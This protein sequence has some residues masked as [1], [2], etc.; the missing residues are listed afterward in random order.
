MYIHTDQ[1]RRVFLRRAAQLSVAGVAAPLVGSLGIASEAAAATADDYKALVCVF[2][3]GGNDYANTLPPYDDANYDLYRAAR[4]GLAINRDQLA[5][6]VLHPANDLGGRQYALNPALLPLRPLFDQGKLAVVLNVGALV[7]PTTKSQ[8]QAKS[9]PLPPQLFSHYDQQGYFQRCSPEASPSGWGGRMGDLFAASNGNA[10]LTCIN[11]SGNAVFLSGQSTVPYTVSP[12]GPAALLQDSPSLFGSTV[13]GTALRQI[14][15]SAGQSVFASEHAKVSKHALEI[16]AAVTAALTNA[17]P[18]TF[19]LFPS[20]NPLAD[21]LKMVARLIAVS[22]E[23]GAKRQ[24]FFVS[25]NGFDLHDG[26]PTKHPILLAQVAA[27]MRAFYDTTVQLGVAEKVTSFTAS[28]FGRSLVGNDDGSDHG[29]GSIHFI[30]GG[31]VRGQQIYGKPPAVGANT[32]D[33][34][35]SGRLIPTTSIDQYAATLANW[36]GVS[37]GNL[38]GVLPNLS[39]FNPSSWNVGFL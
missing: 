9:V 26:M 29:W 28:E 32:N 22:S 38:T 10:T 21:Q 34:V 19:T 33:D 31:A 6:S 15:S 20:G 3:Y 18:S 7:Q 12:R 13:A 24:V 23:L 25:L 14:M 35:D 16:N 39:N 17:P 4:P 5:G 30:V 11:A 1:S 8:F 2:L 27:A 36:F 37:A